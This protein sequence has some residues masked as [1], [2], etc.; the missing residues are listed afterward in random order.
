MLFGAI[1]AIVTELF[2]AA[3]FIPHPGLS[4][5]NTLVTLLLRLPSLAM[6]VRRL[7]GEDVE[8]PAGAP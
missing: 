2:D 4:P 3:I 7:H 8:G 1:C 6:T 5:L